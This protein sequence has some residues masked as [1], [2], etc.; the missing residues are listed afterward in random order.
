MRITESQLRRIIRQ[1]AARTLTEKRGKRK[2]GGLE[3]QQDAHLDYWISVWR[4]YTAVSAAEQAL[5]RAQ[6]EAQGADIEKAEAG[7]VKSL[8]AMVAAGVPAD[9]AQTYVEDKAI[10]SGMSEDDYRDVATFVYDWYRD[11][12]PELL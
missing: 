7:I 6:Q 11:N 3:W 5:K 8:T 10:G 2:L 1:E 4:R 12:A 9:D